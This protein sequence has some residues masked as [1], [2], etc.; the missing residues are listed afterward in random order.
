MDVRFGADC[1]HV[2]LA[3]WLNVDDVDEDSK[4][5]YPISGQRHRDTS[6]DEPKALGDARLWHRTCQGCFEL[7]FDCS[8]MLT[9]RAL[10]R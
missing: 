9:I 3:V 7:A 8:N 4:F 6:I 1:V 5:S 2:H 10:G